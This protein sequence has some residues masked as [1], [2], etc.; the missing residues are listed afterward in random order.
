LDEKSPAF[1]EFQVKP[2]FPDSLR[3]GK[4]QIETMRGRISSE[5]EKNPGLFTLKLEV[6]FN[7]SATV[8]IPGSV[9]SKILES[10][11]PFEKVEGLEYLGFKNGNHILKV[12]SGNYLFA[13]I[14][15]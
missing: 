9:K 10:M 11:T 5:W 1:A 14:T 7:T 4:A 13:T 3:F 6:P 8:F 12:H 2:F 15:D